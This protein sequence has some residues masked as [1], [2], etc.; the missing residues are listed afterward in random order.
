MCVSQ[1]LKDP[2][3]PQSK[4]NYWSVDVTRIPLDAM[5]LQNTM[6]ARGGAASF[7]HDLAPYIL[8]NQQY[9]AAGEERHPMASSGLSPAIPLPTAEDF[10]QSNMAGKL[11]TS[12]MMQSLL[13]DLQ[14]V[15][16]ADASLSERGWPT[17][18]R[19]YNSRLFQ[20]C[21]SPNILAPQSFH[22]SSSSS[23]STISPRSADEEPNPG[24]S[25]T[26]V[27]MKRPRDQGSVSSSDSDAES[28]SPGEPPTKVTFQAADLP[29]S[30]TKR[31]PPNAVAPPNI[32]PFF[33]LPQFGYYNYGSSPFMSP[34]YWGLLP[35][36][37]SGPPEPPLP[38]STDLDSMLRVVPPNKSIFDVMSSHPGDV[39]HP[40]FF[41]Q[42]LSSPG[43][44]LV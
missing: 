10:Q 34:A 26:C 43:H 42:Y 33:P 29:T 20:R 37:A 12:F 32:L 4:G 31:V 27:V 24:S 38:P 28:R 44:R 9:V 13:Q 40:A 1:V 11:N 16:L 7:A 17:N 14:A 25:G 23:L 19:L 36:A 18:R 3:K 5:K 8:H 30:Y 39:V 2:G 22:S 15:D 41:S 21:S 6:M 35:K